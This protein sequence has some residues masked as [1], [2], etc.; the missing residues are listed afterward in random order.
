MA[1]IIVEVVVLLISRANLTNAAVNLVNS[2]AHRGEADEIPR[3]TA[4]TQLNFRGLIKS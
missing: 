3:F 4:V 2:A 1:V